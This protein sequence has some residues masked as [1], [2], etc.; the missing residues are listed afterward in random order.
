LAKNVRDRKRQRRYALRLPVK[1]R[2]TGERQWHEGTTISLSA[3]GVVIEGNVL[4]ARD[5]HIVVVIALPSA[6][7]CLNGRGRIVRASAL[8]VRAGHCSFAI[9]VPHYRLERRVAAERRL[10]V[11][12]QGC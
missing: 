6:G 4:P 2:T 3:S 9:A 1:Y 11:L 8:H 12:L 5:Q 7:G 10:D